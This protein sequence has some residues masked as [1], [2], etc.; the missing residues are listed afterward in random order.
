M[1]MYY[2][3][4]F[5]KHYEC[6]AITSPY[7]LVSSTAALTR[8][9]LLTIGWEQALVRLRVAKGWKHANSTPTKGK[10]GQF[11]WHEQMTELDGDIQFCRD[12][13][14]VVRVLLAS[15][16]DVNARSLNYAY[17]RLILPC[18]EASDALDF[19]FLNK[20]GKIYFMCWLFVR[21]QKRSLAHCA[22]ENM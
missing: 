12:M 21:N 4:S 15:A 1:R 16:L 2:H 19:F 13:T 20:R 17:P 8:E 3:Y 18:L 11:Y 7:W 10:L 5:N 9:P 22:N 14:K 6:F